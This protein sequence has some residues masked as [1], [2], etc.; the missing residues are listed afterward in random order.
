MNSMLDRFVREV[1]VV[2]LVCLAAA[3]CGDERGPTTRESEAAQLREARER[4]VDVLTQA[5]GASNQWKEILSR[6][7]SYRYSPVM[8]LELQRL[9]VDR[10]RPILFLGAMRD[11]ERIDAE[12]Y[13]VVIEES[14][15]V[16]LDHLFSTP[17]RLSLDVRKETLDEF[18]LR[19][20]NL[21]GASETDNGVVVAA[22]ISSVSSTDYV[23]EDGEIHTLKTGHGR[24]LGIVFVGNEVE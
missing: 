8:T 3:S 15:W 4:A 10:G 17:L 13:R 23:R 22:R 7:Q 1:V 19:N 24:L 14:W 6:G 16:T 11:I 5:H 12:Q 9:W 20:P 2:L 21:I 18:L